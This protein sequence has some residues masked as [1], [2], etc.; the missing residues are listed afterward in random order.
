MSFGDDLER[1]RERILRLVK[2][3]GAGWAEAM[4]AHKLAPPNEDFADRLQQLSEA[5]AAEQLAW[6]QAHEAGMS[7][8]PIPGAEQAEPPYELRPASG[9]RGPDDIW[10]RF[11][12]AVGELNRA[13]SRSSAERVAD[14]FGALATV[15]AELSAAVAQED[16]IKR[17]AR[18]MSKAARTSAA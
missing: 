2:H 18:A 14:A 11:D 13:I 10:E 8:R 15:A 9:R 7:W 16:D 6:Q 3:A 4:R 12:H 17:Q 1:E 5:A